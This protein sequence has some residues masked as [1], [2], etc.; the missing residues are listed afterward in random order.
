MNEY[1]S[2]IEV[3]FRNIE[4]I[5]SLKTGTEEDS[6]LVELNEKVDARIYH[7]FAI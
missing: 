6:L 1:D 4:L 2:I 5:T 3:N 7:Y